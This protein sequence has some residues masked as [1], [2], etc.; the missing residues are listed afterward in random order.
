MTS[1]SCDYDVQFSLDP[2]HSSRTMLFKQ[3]RGKYGNFDD[4][5]C[6]RVDRL[7]AA[8]NLIQVI[9]HAHLL[10]EQALTTRL[11]AKF[12]RPDV[13]NGNRFASLSFAQKIT[14][15]VG[16]YAPEDWILETLVGFNRLR[17][18]IAHEIGD[19]AAAVARCLP[20]PF[21]SHSNPID[22]VVGAFASI[23]FF[24]LQALHGIARTDSESPTGHEGPNQVMQRTA[25]RPH[26]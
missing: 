10:L 21:R 1:F 3:I 6:D 17:N 5:L 20:E 23:A 12:A 25:K 11:T 22:G 7:F 18:S 24:E 13:L 19:E 14:V 16:L 9:L 4:A 8:E 15:Y 2:R 26:T